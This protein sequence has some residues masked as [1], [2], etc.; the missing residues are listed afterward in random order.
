MRQPTAAVAVPPVFD[1]YFTPSRASALGARTVKT[2]LEQY[3]F[4]TEL[5]NFPALRKRGSRQ[6]LPDELNHLKPHIID[7]ET[8]PLSFFTKYQRFGPDFHEC[9]A[10]IKSSGAAFLFISC[11]AW[12]Y[13]ESAARLAEAVKKFSPETMII[14]GGAGAT[15][16]PSYF[17]DCPHIDH[18][19]CG[20]AENVLG[21]FL[22]Y[23]AGASGRSCEAKALQPFVPAA[24]VNEG[25]GKQ[26]ITRVTLSVS[27][28]CPNR[29]SF[30][31]NF[32][33]HGREFRKLPVPA[34][35]NLLNSLRLQGPLH[36]NF[37]DDNLLADTG[38]FLD[39]LELLG[40]KYPGAVF[41]AE[42]GLEYNLLSPGL[43][44]QLT[45]LGFRS[46]NLSMASSDSVMLDSQNRPSTP[47]RLK[48]IAEVLQARDILSTVYFICGMKNETID[49]TALNLLALHDMPALTGIS[50][51]YPVPGLPGFENP[52]TFSKHKPF[53]CAGSSAWP[54]NGSLSTAGLITAFRLARLSNMIKTLTAQ[55]PGTRK[56][57][58]SGQDRLLV[59]EIFRERRLKTFSGK[60]IAE[61]PEADRRLVE[62]FLEQALSPGLLD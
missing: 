6:S 47:G 35:E 28:G 13:A 49:S 48:E 31:S 24:A 18:V 50:M 4:E 59:K 29:C 55:I 38:Y 27:R 25:R 21:D 52:E 19:L 56:E 10:M 61:V 39:L 2:I 51:F 26:G 41:T 20:E 62:N 46:F 17:R 34:V 7:N 42:N 15:V 8:G 23:E 45:D 54:W 22:R 12:A 36:F 11:F 14:A 58:I 33:V 1:F 9:A 37:E 30:C 57:K 44:E 3:G 32:L 43:A 5:F 53:L 60:E 16:N 40:R